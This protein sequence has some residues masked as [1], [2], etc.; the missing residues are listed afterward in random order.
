MVTRDFDHLI[1]FVEAYIG[2]LKLSCDQTLMV[3]MWWG[4]L[5]QYN[6]VDKASLCTS[7]SA[8]Y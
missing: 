2:T 5:K 8:D 1:S 6:V 3:A 7:K 4:A